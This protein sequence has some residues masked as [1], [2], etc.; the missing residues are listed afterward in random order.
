MRSF[1]AGTLLKLYTMMLRLRM[2]EE[3]IAERYVD[4]EI[5]MYIHLYIGQ[6]A[7]ATGVCANLSKD[8]YVY[9]NHRSHGHYLAQGGSLKCLFSELMG[10]ATGCSSGKGGS[11]HLIDTSVGYMGSSSIVAGNIPIAVGTALALAMRRTR[12]ISVTFFG[13]G[14]ADEGV[15]YESL[16]FAALKGLPVLFVCENNFYAICSHQSKRQKF[17]NIFK[18]CG[19]FGVPGMRIDGNDVSRVYAASRDIITAMRGGKGPYLL[20]CRTYRLLGHGG[21]KYD[22]DLG[23]RTKKELEYW[24]VKCPI[25]RLEK[26]LFGKGA[27]ND[28]IKARIV[29]RVER[30][31]DE[32]IDFARKSPVPKR[33]DLVKDVTS[34]KRMR[35]CA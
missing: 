7:I 10:R 18:R 9:S 25:R 5:C 32:A 30:E 17:D 8:D 21:P 27:L 35:I 1:P 29:R 12:R 6:E 13:D 23:Y 11:M 31:I 28:Q 34:G 4:K 2:A 3:A 14:A 19:V 16:N 26:F 22:T 20:E 24:Q 33:C 15:F